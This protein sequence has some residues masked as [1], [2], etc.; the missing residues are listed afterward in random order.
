MGAGN[1]FY[2]SG[3]L[4]DADAAK[5]SQMV[6][7]DEYT[8]EDENGEYL[9]TDYSVHEDVL[10]LLKAHLPGFKA[11]T[12]PYPDRSIHSLGYCDGGRLLGEVGRLA[13]LAVPTYYGDKTAIV[14]TLNREYQENVSLVSWYLKTGDGQCQLETAED[15][16]DYEHVFKAV[17]SGS[18][19][20][21]IAETF[22]WILDILAE[23][24]NMEHMM[25]FRACCWTSSSYTGLKKHGLPLRSNQAF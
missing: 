21:E 19:E 13:V 15:R 1:Y 8:D 3:Y 12:D 6:Y 16:L 25:S 10:C 2:Q 23:H 22:A 18:L 24:G 11:A 17:N 5:Y 20:T 14:L 4:E 9:Y 7:V